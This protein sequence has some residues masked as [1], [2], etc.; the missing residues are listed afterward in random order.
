VTPASR[1]ALVQPRWLSQGA[2][3]L[4]VLCA[5]IVAV[6][7]VRARLSPHG[8]GLVVL[9]GAAGT[10]TA[11]AFFVGGA[12]RVMARLPFHDR[13][14]RLAD[15]I[16]LEVRRV[17]L[18]LLG[19]A[20]FLVWTFVYLSLWAIHPHEAFAGLDP[21]PRFADF[22]YYAVSTAFVSPP[23]DIFAHSRGARSATMIEMLTGFALLATYLAS[24]SDWQRRE[25]QADPPAPL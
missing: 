7:M 20:F 9:V 17:G 10:L 15:G 22:F 24:F 12:R 19:L 2:L 1:V 13:S 5:F 25:T 4:L 23:G 3:R 21:S 11:L 14:Q 8:A 6:G 18:P 16:L